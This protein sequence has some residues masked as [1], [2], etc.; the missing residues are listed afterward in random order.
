MKYLLKKLHP[1][2]RR[3]KKKKIRAHPNRYPPNT[4]RLKSYVMASYQLHNKLKV[5]YSLCKILGQDSLKV[6]NIVGWI[7]L[8]PQISNSI[9]QTILLGLLLVLLRNVAYNELEIG[10]VKLSL[11][12]CCAVIFICCCSRCFYWWLCCCTLRCL[13]CSS[14]WRNGGVW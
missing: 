1:K 12:V 10:S 11:T 3:Q 9:T 13:I 7:A 6:C 4:G 5:Q 2:H 8:L 14:R